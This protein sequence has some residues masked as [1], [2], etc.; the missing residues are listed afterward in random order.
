MGGGGQKILTFNDPIYFFFLEGSTIYF[1]FI[2]FWGG[3]GGYD[4]DP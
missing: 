1:Y 4:V 3:V 2:F